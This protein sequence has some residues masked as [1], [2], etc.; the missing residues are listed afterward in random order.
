M[1][2]LTL[3]NQ[4]VLQSTIDPATSEEHPYDVL[5]VGAGP[6]GSSTAYHLFWQGAEVLLV[7]RLPFPRDKRCG[8]G[9][10]TA[11]LEELALMELIEEVKAL[12][13][14]AKQRF[15]NRPEF[16]KALEQA[17]LEH[18]SVP[19]KLPTSKPSI[20]S[21]PNRGVRPWALALGM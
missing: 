3:A 7:D 2:D 18:K 11:T 16:A 15:A 1:N 19:Q 4:S 21:L 8:D 20:T 13:K 6:T 14:E 17:N 10:V 12:S 9:I 5:V